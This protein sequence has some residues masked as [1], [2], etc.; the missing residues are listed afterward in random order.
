MKQVLPRLLR[1][2]SPARELSRKLTLMFESTRPSRRLLLEYE[3]LEDASF[4]LDELSPNNLQLHNKG[5]SSHNQ[6]YSLTALR[7]LPEKQVRHK[8]QMLGWH[9]G[10]CHCTASQLVY[11]CHVFTP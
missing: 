6:R 5:K 8:H 10:L 2:H 3:L 9:L 11:S 1:P 4:W 7:Y